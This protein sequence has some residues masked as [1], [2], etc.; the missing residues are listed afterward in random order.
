MTRSWTNVHFS[1]S[2]PIE[3]RECLD[4]LMRAKGSSIGLQFKRALIECLLEAGVDPGHL[5]RLPSTDD[6]E[7]FDDNSA[8]P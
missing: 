3:D 5:D 7:G 1:F 6:R 2:L 8:H 4:E